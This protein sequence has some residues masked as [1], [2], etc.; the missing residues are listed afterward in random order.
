MKIQALRVTLL[1]T[2]VIESTGRIMGPSWRYQYFH[3]NFYF[4]PSLIGWNPG[5]QGA[6]RER[7]ASW[8]GDLWK[9]L[10]CQVVNTIISKPLLMFILS[11]STHNNSKT[12]PYVYFVRERETGECAAAKYLRQVKISLSR[13]VSESYIF[14]I[15]LPCCQE[16]HKVR[17]EAEVLRS[18][19]QSAFVVQLVGL[20]ESMMTVMTGF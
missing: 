20:F 9:R 17:R 8:V 3:F 2:F 18:L 1:R 14:R 5:V 11:G 7:G 15:H 16:K 10:F 12:T 4:N 19:I 13:V 6:V